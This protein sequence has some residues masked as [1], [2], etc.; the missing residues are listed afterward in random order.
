MQALSTLY[1]AENRRNQ[2]I[3][4]PRKCNLAHTKAERQVG[5]DQLL[6]KARRFGCCGNPF[7][8]GLFEYLS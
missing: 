8:R 6:V 4:G 2:L 5:H 3:R 1:Q 7:H